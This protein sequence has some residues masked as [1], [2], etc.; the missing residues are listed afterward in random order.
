MSVDA[1]TLGIKEIKKQLVEAAQRAVDPRPVLRDVADDVRSAERAYLGRVRW[2]P[3]SPEY[4]A[5]KARAGRGSRVD[6]YSGE[7]FDSL[8]QAGHRYHHERVS[9]DGLEVGSKDPVARMFDKG[10][11]AQKKRKLIRL[12]PRD[13]REMLLTIRDYLLDPT[14]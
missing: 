12:T 8:T 14:R 6:V 13:R 4:A 3:V 7:L 2:A 9:A 11:G 5:R 10:T 1:T